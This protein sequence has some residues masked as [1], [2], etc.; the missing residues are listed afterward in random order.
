MKFLYRPIA[1]FLILVTSSSM[2]WAGDKAE[3]S[4]FLFLKGRPVKNAELLINGKAFADFSESGSVFGSLAPGN[5]Q[6]TINRENKSFGF[7]LPLRKDEDVQVILTFP[8]YKGEPVW[9][10]RFGRGRFRLYGHST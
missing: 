9:T 10:G 8:E 2:V 5:Y 1:I 7:A 4:I 6:M 3:F